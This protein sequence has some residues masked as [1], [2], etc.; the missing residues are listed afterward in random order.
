MRRQCQKMARLRGVVAFAGVERV[1][2]LVLLLTSLWTTFS[3]FVGVGDNCQLY[4]FSA[5]A[6]VR[7]VL[8][9]FCAYPIGHTW[10]AHSTDIKGAI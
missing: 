3:V 6:F 10:G 4:A 8:R 2:L 7:D 9:F 5:T 1:V